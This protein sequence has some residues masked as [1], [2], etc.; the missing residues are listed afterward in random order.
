MS[1]SRAFVS[2]TILFV[3]LYATCSSAF[4]SKATIFRLSR[5]ISKAAAAAVT[6][7]ILASMSISTNS[8]GNGEECIQ[9]KKVGIIGGGAA[10]LATARAFLRENELN[11]NTQYDVT[12]LES[13]DS[14]GGIW[15]YE[16]QTKT[17]KNRPMYRNLR[18]N[19]PKELMA[20][21]ELPWGSDGE[22]SYVTHKDVLE[23]LEAYA[24]KFDLLKCITFG[25]SVKQ[26][27]V[28]D[29][30]QISLEWTTNAG[31]DG[32]VETHK[33][34][35]D[36][37]CV[38]NGHYAR[39]AIPK[40]EGLDTFHGDI[41]HAIEYDNAQPYAGK[42]V[43]CVGA[44]P[45]GLDISREIGLVAK[46]VYLS[47]S[48]CDKMQTFGNVSLMPRMQSVDENGGVHFSSPR[49]A[50][51]HVADDVD[52]IV[53]CSGY[54]YDFPFINE[55][56]NLEL[57]FTPGERR[58]QPLYEQTWHA[59]CPSVSFIGIPHSI[60]PFPLCEIQAAAVGSQTRQQINGIPLPCLS[61]RLAAASEDAASGGPN[62]ARVQ[63][64]HNLASHQWD[65]C[66]KLAKISG[67]YDDE[68]EKFIATNK[69]IYDRSGK[70]RKSMIPGG[71][72]VYRET[73]FRRNDEN[74]SYDILYSKT[75]AESTV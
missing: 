26:L 22:A 47:D 66:R 19:L 27:T 16:D 12:V 72:D 55:E 50:E 63:E 25:S 42:T 65:F 14:I 11:Q 33:E 36:N 17:E 58:V 20:Y 68:M 74:Q 34:T 23:Y 57:Q 69:A 1:S 45:S 61:D 4:Q 37:V 59:R 6:S 3:L 30:D 32:N 8:N 9:T 51:E 2:S 41:I 5:T 39:P 71:E 24:N 73:R 53:F 54:D 49:S 31:E 15:K 56:S 44:K 64:T 70:E 52:A 13:R 35:F 43:L 40:L 18:T 10:G 21:R 28:L 46:H 62:G 75:E 67:D 7:R 38:C 60:V 29:D 48:A